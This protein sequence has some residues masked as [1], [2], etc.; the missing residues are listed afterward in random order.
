MFKS[1]FLKYISVFIAIVFSGFVILTLII[2]SIF[3][4]Y[5]QKDKYSSL[6]N[7][8]SSISVYVGK[9]Y[10]N[11]IIGESLYVDKEYYERLCIVVDLLTVKDAECSVVIVHTDGSI[12]SIIYPSNRDETYL[13]PIFAMDVSDVRIPESYMERISSLEVVSDKGNMGG[14]LTENIMFSGVPIYIEGKLLGG[15]FVG[16][17]N[18]GMSDIVES[19]IKTMIMSSLWI[20]LASVIAVYIISMRLISPLREMSVASKAFA[21]GNFDARIKVQ[22][23]DEVAQLAAAFND[24]ATS[25]QSLEYMRSSFVSSVSHELR[26]PMTSIGG[27]IDSILDGA[28]PKEEQKHY[29]GIISE[30]IKRLSRLVTSLLQ[31]SR[32]ESGNAKLN[33]VSFDIC[34]LA[35][36]ILISNEQ[37]I[38]EKNLD[39]SF[40]CDDDNINVIADRDFIHQVLFNLCDNAIKFSKPGG[41]YS[42]TINK[43]EKNKVKVGVLNEGDGIPEEDLPFIFERFYKSDKSRGLDKTGVGLGLYIVKCIINNH[44]ENINVE[45]EY[46]KW[47][48]FTFTLAL[49]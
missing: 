12:C 45:S 6:Q 41:K 40:E 3:G 21:K 4:S 29:L 38:D 43:A 20:M 13:A 1:L 8:A 37:R 42:I 30:E 19:M 44:G 27:F 34:E 32:I 15:V 22:G 47:T 17:R 28:I 48:R 11:H 23:R 10:K 39:V 46:G 49:E 26:T 9:D 5:A 16:T 14:Q 31:I 24:M 7:V 18:L 36:V 33:M 2:T 25:L 35:R